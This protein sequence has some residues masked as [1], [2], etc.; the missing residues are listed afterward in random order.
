MKTILVVEDESAIATLLSMVL[1]DEGYRVVLAAD[2]RAGLTRL[3]EV[4]PD[5]IICDVMMPLLDGI[6]MCRAVQN[7]PD[8]CSIPVVLMTAARKSFS[9]DHCDYATILYKPFELDT[10]LETVGELIGEVIPQ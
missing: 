1:E 9:R 10:L 6:E 3:A 5:L 4:R 2:G 8:Y 7:N